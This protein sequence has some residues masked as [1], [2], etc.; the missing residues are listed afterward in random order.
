MGKISDKLK[1]LHFSDQLTGAVGQPES[2]A[3]TIS[4]LSG[5]RS[6]TP[7]P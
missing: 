6:R 5:H 2:I 4:G 3:V 7:L 1:Q